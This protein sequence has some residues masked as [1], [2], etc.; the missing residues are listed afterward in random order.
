MATE[1]DIPEPVYSVVCKIFLFSS[2]ACFFTLVFSVYNDVQRMLD[3]WLLGSSET[4]REKHI[5]FAR[6]SATWEQ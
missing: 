2:V 5:R 1:G 6:S 4:F 3:S